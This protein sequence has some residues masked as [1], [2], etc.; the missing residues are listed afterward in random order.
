[1]QQ[2]MES[3]NKVATSSIIRIDQE[4]S[5]ESQDHYQKIFAPNLQ[6]Y[7]SAERLRSAILIIGI[8]L[9]F[10]KI[11]GQNY[12]LLKRA[13]H[14]LTQSISRYSFF[15]NFTISVRRFSDN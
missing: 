10:R 6:K 9:L 15:R 2:Y 14:S 1:M 12:L 11:R 5:L 8:I 13:H 7:Q 3:D 4:L